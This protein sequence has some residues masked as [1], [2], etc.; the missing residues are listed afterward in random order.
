MGTITVSYLSITVALVWV[1]LIADQ[2]TGTAWF[3][4][5]K[6]SIM[7]TDHFDIF[8]DDDGGELDDIITA[9]LS[10]PG[11]RLAADEMVAFTILTDSEL[12]EIDAD[13]DAGVYEPYEDIDAWVQSAEPHEDWQQDEIDYPDHVV[14]GAY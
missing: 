3:Q 2:A 5:T 14:G 13:I 6:G 11:L 7:N 1:C 10:I 8:A 4:Q 12:A 9:T